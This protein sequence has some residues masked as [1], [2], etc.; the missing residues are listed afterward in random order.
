MIYERINVDYTPKT[1][2]LTM[3]LGKKNKELF[4]GKRL[5]DPSL[6]PAILLV[7]QHGLKIIATLAPQKNRFDVAINGYWIYQYPYKYEGGKLERNK[8]L[9]DQAQS[10]T[11]KTSEFVL[12]E[13]VI[14][15]P[16]QERTLADITQKI[17]KKLGTF[18]PIITK[19][20]VKGIR[21]DSGPFCELFDMLL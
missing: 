5:T 3:Q 14:L 10:Q 7:A 11:I 6:F 19:I 20:I 13:I 21:C 8:A 15:E 2:V 4:K 17:N 9:V 12:N 1:K 18:D 16:E